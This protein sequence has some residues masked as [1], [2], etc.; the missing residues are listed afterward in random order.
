MAST[1]I[2]ALVVLALTL[3]LA[4]RAQKESGARWSFELFG[5]SAASFATRLTIH[6]SGFDDI[7]MTAHYATRP[8]TGAP[9][10]AARI[11]RWSHD[12]AWELEL[13]HHKLYLTNPPPEIQNFEV[14]HGY[15]LIT[16]NRAARYGG[17]IA[18]IGV[19][20][21]VVHPD[22][23]VHGQPLVSSK[24]NLGRGYSFTGPTLQIAAEKRIAL[25][26]QLCLGLE[27]KVT[28]SYA[29]F[30]VTGGSATTPNVA[31]HGLL[32]FGWGI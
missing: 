6:Q 5:G 22:A 2:V 7:R 9:Y 28:A 30:S 21:I 14:T 26:R 8:W 17:I 19:G 25:W 27:G 3:P 20:A 23:S 18:R 15:N 32:G 29:R 13:L 24:G 31:V 11:G 4:S 12:R 10:Y 16:L 1:R